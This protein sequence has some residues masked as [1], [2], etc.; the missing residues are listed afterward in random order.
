MSV[1]ITNFVKINIKNHEFIGI[2]G[3]RPTSLILNIVSD[4]SGYEDIECTKSDYKSKLN[5]DKYKD[6]LTYANIY[7]DNGGNSLKI[8]FATYNG[9]T[10]TFATNN[11]G[12]NVSFIELIKFIPIE[13]VVMTAL[14]SRTGTSNKP[15]NFKNKIERLN[16]EDGVYHKIFVEEYTIDKLNNDF[17]TTLNTDT[18]PENYVIKFG[19]KGISATVL[20][21]YSKIDIY[22]P[23][24]ANDYAFTLEKFTSL[25]NDL[26]EKYYTENN[27]NVVNVINNNL[28]IDAILD[29][30]NI[31]NIGGN[32]IAG[33]ELTNQ[34]MLILLHQTLS[35]RLLQVLIN[36]IK[37]NDIGVATILG[38]INQEL[39]R[40][41]NNG[42]LYQD[43][44]WTDSDLYYKNT[45]IIN[46]NTPLTT[47]YKVVI[48]PFSTLEPDDIKAHKLPD[49]YILIG[50]SYFIRQINITG[51]VF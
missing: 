50:D 32:D 45:L 38:A 19:D 42:Y 7:F 34:Y 49:I 43:K 14:D 46:E 47:G 33:Q 23:N 17:I 11:F 13:Y 35:Q 36:K 22:K 18:K 16:N 48:L 31:R 29:Q 2:S 24:V 30:S 26:K 28:N 10:D 12:T 27:S 41:V 40:Y 20:A 21:Y 44:I 37:Y 3:S 5:D 25:G 39:N 6:L 4:L 51:E 9:D 15:L 8:I 1:Q